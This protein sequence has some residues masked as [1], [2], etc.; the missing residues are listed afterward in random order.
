MSLG[1][2]EPQLVTYLHNRGP[3]TALPFVRRFVLLK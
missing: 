1:Q 3:K 2:T